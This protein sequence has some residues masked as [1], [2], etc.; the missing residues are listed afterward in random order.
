MLFRSAA[1]NLGVKDVREGHAFRYDEFSNPNDAWN[2]ER[3]R[4]FANC[5]SGPV[6]VNKRVNGYAM[7]AASDLL[8]ANII[9]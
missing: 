6:K 7:I 9:F 1:F 2:Y 8:K 4:I 3:G 5:Y